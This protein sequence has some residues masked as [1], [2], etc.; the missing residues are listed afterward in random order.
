MPKKIAPMTD[1]QIKNAK[2]QSEDYSHYDGNGLLFQST[3]TKKWQFRHYRPITNNRTIVSFGSYPEV[4]PQQARKQRYE[5]RELIKGG[6]D[7]NIIEAALL[8]SILIV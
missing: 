3:G 6:I 5:M 2:S 1:T 7:P 8:T 4:S